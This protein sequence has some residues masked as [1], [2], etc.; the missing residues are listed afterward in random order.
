MEKLL[1]QF[2]KMVNKPFIDL[3]YLIFGA[4][5]LFFINLIY[6]FDISAISNFKNINT[7]ILTIFF[8]AISYYIGRM[9]KLVSEIWII[10]FQLIFGKDRKKEFIKLFKEI[11][12]QID[13]ISETI[14]PSSS[15]IYNAEIKKIIDK[16][17]SIK[18]RLDREILSNIFL[19]LNIGLVIV[20]L[21]IKFHYL[22]IIV[23]LLLTFF[24]IR[25]HVDI[26]KMEKDL[27]T[28]YH[29]EKK[30]R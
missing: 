21:V 3:M 27:M 17:E 18:A 20:L 11:K 2:A 26:F 16:N 12:N 9:L 24:E 6:T 25:G 10:L 29:Q 19:N 5:F 22:L 15:D 30:K 28:Y 7:L 13:G 23:L 8:V 1:E 14:E 4:I